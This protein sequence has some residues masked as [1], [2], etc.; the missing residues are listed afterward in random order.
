MQSWL[1]V[2]SHSLRLTLK[3]IQ[4]VSTLK[5]AETST[6]LLL[7]NLLLCVILHLK[8]ML[9][10]WITSQVLRVQIPPGHMLCETKSKAPV[11]D[12][13]HNITFFYF[14]YLINSYHIF[15]TIRWIPSLI[16][17]WKFLRKN[18]FTTCPDKI[19]STILQNKDNSVCL[20]SFITAWTSASMYTACCSVISYCHT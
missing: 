4:F 13:L 20:S 14:I 5:S 9:V 1:G 11:W 12:T 15:L 18:N 7:P 8:K 16:W 2:D 6:I 17:D 19:C 3:A 10:K